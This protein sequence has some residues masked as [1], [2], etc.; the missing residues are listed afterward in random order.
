MK[1]TP[2]S[3]ALHSIFNADGQQLATGVFIEEGKPVSLPITAWVEFRYDGPRRGR[4]KNPNRKMAVLMAHGWHRLW[5]KM[6]KGEA[7]S[8]L[9]SLGF[10]S[11]ERA[12]TRARNNNNNDE[13]NDLYRI[14]S[15]RENPTNGCVIA[16]KKSAAIVEVSKE[17]IQFSGPGWVWHY[18][19]KEATYRDL[20]KCKSSFEEPLGDQE[21][22][23]YQQWARG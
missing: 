21:L 14:F 18:G 7:D 3:L 11:D 17:G 23:N 4:K 19:E 22:A 20:W 13:I 2:L 8:A 9:V 6:T 10:Y 15:W 16:L 1:K 5:L 12:V